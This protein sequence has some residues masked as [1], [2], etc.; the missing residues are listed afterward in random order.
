MPEKPDGT[1]KPDQVKKQVE[2]LMSLRPS[3]PDSFAFHTGA[4]EPMKIVTADRGKEYEEIISI[5]VIVQIQ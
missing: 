4:Q 2:L 1:Y 5:D 3:Y